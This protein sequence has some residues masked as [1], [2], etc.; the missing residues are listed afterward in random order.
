[1]NTYKAI[2]ALGVCIPQKTFDELLNSIT[3]QELH[4]VLRY[5]LL[6]H[7]KGGKTFRFIDT[8]KAPRKGEKAAML[9]S[10][11]ELKPNF[12]IPEAAVL[13]W[14]TIIPLGV[15]PVAKTSFGSFHLSHT[16]T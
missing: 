11:P 2:S 16:Q 13:T 12:T 10:C 9:V 5:F 3:I 4:S 6:V 1:M 14:S 15:G 7:T 8:S